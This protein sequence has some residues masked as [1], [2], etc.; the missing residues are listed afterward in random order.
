M[1]NFEV[2]FM[3]SS[4]PQSRETFRSQGQEKLRLKITDNI[5]SVHKK[6]FEILFLAA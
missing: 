6:H 2:N 4:F 1:Y 3:E 5:R